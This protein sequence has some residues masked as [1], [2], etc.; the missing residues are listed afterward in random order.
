[1]ADDTTRPDRA[2]Y[3]AV[4]DDARAPR[5]GEA[6]GA[7]AQEAREDATPATSRWRRLGKAVGFGMLFAVPVAA[8]AFVTREK[9]LPVI[10]LDTRAIRAATDITRANPVL[11][12]ALLVWQEMTQPKWPYIVA[13]GLCIWVWRRYGLKSR[14]IWAFVTMMVAWNVQLVIKE[15]VRRARPVV[16][17]PVSHA[18]GFSFPSGHAANAAATATALILLVWPICSPRARRIVVGSG[19]AYVLVTMLDRVFLGAHFPSDV[20]A[21]L[22]VGSGL[23]IASYLGYVG[24][25]PARAN[26]APPPEG[27]TGPEPTKGPR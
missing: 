21:G 20:V 24:W 11:R 27:H 9:F 15:V 10:E 6:P 4:L 12:D 18:P 3:D 1:M 8:L 26:D 13:T 7:P 2:A 25:N 19:V 23:V 17:D 22:L 5:R 14:A 16:S